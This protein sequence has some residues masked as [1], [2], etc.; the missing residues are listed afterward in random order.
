MKREKQLK[1][2]TM[3][4]P[5]QLAADLFV[6]ANAKLLG[7]YSTTKLVL[8]TSHWGY[9]QTSKIIHGLTAPKKISMACTLHLK[10]RNNEEWMQLSHKSNKA[11]VGLSS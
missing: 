5:R 9:K 10:K 1:L 4:I 11:N 2:Y 7:K 3:S 8:W 6:V